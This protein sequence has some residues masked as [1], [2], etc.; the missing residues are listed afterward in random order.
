MMGQVVDEPF[1]GLY[2]NHWILTG[3]D[4]TLSVFVFPDA[5]YIAPGT[6]DSLFN[7][8]ELGG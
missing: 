8:R 3:L 2:Q 4:W 6:Q 5:S 7:I 1:P